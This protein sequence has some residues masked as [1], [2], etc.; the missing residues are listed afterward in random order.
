M[1]TKL[2]LENIEGKEHS[3]NLNIDDKIIYT[4]YILCVGAGLAQAV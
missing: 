2:Y 4:I 3:H 1:L